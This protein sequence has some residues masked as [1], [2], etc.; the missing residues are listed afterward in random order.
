MKNVTITS[1]EINE[2]KAG[3]KLIEEIENGTGYIY[4]SQ[5]QKLKNLSEI[6]SD[7][8]EHAELSK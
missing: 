1:D 7:I 2:L 4:T 6:L 8:V 5:F 3:I